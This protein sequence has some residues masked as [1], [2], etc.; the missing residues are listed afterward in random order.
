M[1]VYEWQDIA[2]QFTDGLVLGN[3][4]S[5]AFDGQFAYQSLRDRAQTDGLITPDVQ[6]V[7][8]HLDTVD[9][10]L[11]LRMLWHANRINQ[12]LGIDEP[13][14]ANAYESVRDAL[15]Q[16]VGAIHVGYEVVADRLQLAASFM[17]HFRTV[18]ALSYDVL[19]YWSILAGNTSDAGHRFKDC[20]VEPGGRFRQ[21]WSTLRENIAPVTST[22]IVAYPHGNL[23][24]AADYAG[25]ECKLSAG[26]GLLQTIF[27]RW[28]S[29]AWGPMFVS[30]GTTQQ[31]VASIR[32]SPYLST[33]LGEVLPSMSNSVAI[34]GWS[35]GEN[36]VH[37]LNAVCRGRA[38]RFAVA[39][40]PNANDLGLQ[41]ARVIQL[42]TER[43]PAAQVNF[44]NRG[45][46]GCWLVAP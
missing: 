29:G 40:D 13:R 22:T 9:F 35:I 36:D 18:A 37:I 24:L 17:S 7:F 8:D 21:T 14:T 38:L 15:I 4:A 26:G 44:F 10:E 45:S 28:G 33:V 20:F 39:V 46:A 1:P 30:E 16:V 42:I 31:K 11:V 41:Q 32:R 12:A 27:D 23:A 34:F 2:H 25:D 19:V 43:L 6:L 3:G 5:I